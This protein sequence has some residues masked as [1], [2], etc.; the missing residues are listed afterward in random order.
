MAIT[1]DGT[2]LD[3]ESPT[4]VAP[5]AVAPILAFLFVAQQALCNGMT[6][7]E[8]VFPTQFINQCPMVVLFALMSA[9]STCVFVSQIF[10]S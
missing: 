3:S 2:I 10:L 4:E 9:A 7:S 5:W 8:R 6:V 1:C